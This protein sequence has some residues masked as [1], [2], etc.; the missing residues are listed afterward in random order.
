MP[1]GGGRGKVSHKGRRRHFTSEDELRAEEDKERR[2]REWRERR[3]M[4]SDDE[5]ERGATGPIR[6]DDEDEDEEEAAKQKGV[7]SLIEVENPNRV[8]QKT[9]KMSELDNTPNEGPKLS[10]RERE[11]LERQQAKERFQKMHLE[12][13]TDEAKADLARLAIIRREREEAAKKREE[14]KKAKEAEAK[15]AAE[16][17]A[18]ARKSAGAA[19]PSG[20]R[21]GKR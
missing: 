7:A 9:K 13:K 12:G 14:A 16:A 20:R 11:E 10:R 18:E 2:Q 17:A 15:A 4:G 5:D 6:E 21:R 8:V 1:R 3:G 19:P